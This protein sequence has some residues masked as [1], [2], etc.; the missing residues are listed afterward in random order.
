M[1]LDLGTSKIGIALVNAFSFA[2]INFPK[3]KK[4]S[5][6]RNFLNMFLSRILIILLKLQLPKVAIEIYNTERSHMSISNFA[7]KQIYQS[8]TKIQTEKLWKNYY[9]ENTTIVNFFQDES[10]TCFCQT[11]V[12]RSLF[13]KLI[14]VLYNQGQSPPSIQYHI[15]L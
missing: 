15:C 8:K 6:L 9:R 5:S 11:A 10:L 4:P 14:F 3:N 1:R 7:P 2:S 12:R 13:C